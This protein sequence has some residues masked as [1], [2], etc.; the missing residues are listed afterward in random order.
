MDGAV[1]DVVAAVDALSGGAANRTLIVFTSDNGPWLKQK[2]QGGSAGL[3]RGGKFNTWEGGIRVPGIARWRGV[4]APGRTSYARV[5]AYDLFATV[6][7]LGLGGAANASAATRARG[8][9]DGVVDG[10]DLAP[11]LRGDVDDEGRALAPG[12]AAL[13]A[14]GERCLFHYQ[15]VDVAGFGPGLWAVR[16]GSYKM[17]FASLSDKYFDAT[18]GPCCVPGATPFCMREHDPP[19]LYH[20]DYDP[21]EAHPIASDT[22]EYARARARVTRAV[23]E[24]RKTL[25]AVPNQMWEGG[26]PWAVGATDL[27]GDGNPP[28][29]AVVQCCDAD[30]TERWPEH[31]QCTCDPDNWGLHVYLGGEI[32]RY[33]V[34]P[35]CFL[36]DGDRVLYYAVLLLTLLLGGLVGPVACCC[37]CG[38]RLARHWLDARAKRGD[39]SGRADAAPDEPA[40]SKPAA[41]EPAASEPTEPEPAEARTGERPPGGAQLRAPAMEATPEQ[42]EPHTAADDAEDAIGCLIGCGSMGAPGTEASRRGASL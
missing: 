19:L 32:E 17:H 23:D 1:G 4:I 21:S 28:L 24:H 37:A 7:S 35:A 34:E 9:Y 18:D 41:S 6:L 5:A 39:R 31:P 40:A 36:C 12:G 2:L 13:G 3:L 29:D 42:A 30:S 22:D 16:C 11:L 15:G 25:T 8:Q 20:I 26:L 33:D 14:L 27:A 38:A 10:V